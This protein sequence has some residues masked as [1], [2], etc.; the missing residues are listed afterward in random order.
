MGDRPS[1]RRKQARQVFRLTLG[2]LGHLVQGELFPVVGLEK[3]Q[4]LL[5]PDLVRPLGGGEGPPGEFLLVLR[6]GLPHLA[7]EAVD[8]QLIGP[9]L[10]LAQG[11]GLAEPLQHGPLPGD[12]RPEDQ[13]PPAP[14]SPR[15][16]PRTSGR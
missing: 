9:R 7:H 16:G 4:H 5:G 1:T 12:L 13:T 3:G 15:G 14:G 2:R 6:H 11:I 10:R 8:V